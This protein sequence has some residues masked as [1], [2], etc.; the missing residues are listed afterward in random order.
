MWC[1]SSIVEACEAFVVEKAGEVASMHEQACGKAGVRSFGGVPKME[2]IITSHSR[3][4]M[5]QIPTPVHPSALA[6]QPR[7]FTR[8]CE[9]FH[10]T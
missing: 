3:L 5:R 4:G 1:S 9:S 8:P 7:F 2:Q 10:T 6:F